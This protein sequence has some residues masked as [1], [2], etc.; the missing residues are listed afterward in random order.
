MKLMLQYREPGKRS[1][2][3]RWA[4]RPVASVREAI[5]W[6]NGNPDKASLPAFVQTSAWKSETVAILGQA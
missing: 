4:K 1:G 6:L 3:T 2:T 5:E